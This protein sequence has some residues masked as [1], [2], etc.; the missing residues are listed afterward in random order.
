MS[1]KL[2]IKKDGKI[3]AQSESDS[4]SFTSDI[5][6]GTKI[7]NGDFKASYKNSAGESPEI[8]VPE[9]YV[10]QSTMTL[11]LVEFFGDVSGMSKDDKKELSVKYTDPSNKYNF[12]GF[13]KVGWQGMSS[14]NYSKKNYSMKIYTDDTYS[15][16][17]PVQVSD[18]WY[19]TNKYVLKADYVDST[20][21]RNIVGAKL[22]KQVMA[23]PST[24][25]ILG[26]DDVYKK[27]ASNGMYGSIDGFPCEVRINDEFMGLYTFNLDN[28]TEMTNVQDTDIKAIQMNAKGWGNVTM[29]WD[30]NAKLDGSSGDFKLETPDEGDRLTTAQQAVYNWIAFT[31][32]YGF[33][34]FKQNYG[35]RYNIYNVID[36]GLLMN[37]MN[38]QDN[39]CNNVGYL[40]L[41]G[42]M[43]F[44]LPYDMDGAFDLTF[45]GLTDY[46]RKG[47]VVGNKLLKLAFL[48]YPDVAVKRWNDLRKNVFTKENI[49]KILD[50]FKTKVGEYGYTLDKNVWPDIPSRKYATYEQIEQGIDDGLNFM[51]QQAKDGFKIVARQYANGFPGGYENSNKNILPPDKVSVESDEQGVHIKDGE[52][53]ANRDNESLIL[54]DKSGNQV[55]KSDASKEIT[56][57][58]LTSGTKVNTGDYYLIY[59]EENIDSPKVDVPEFTV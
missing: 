56:I 51:D 5:Q 57:T 47:W 8:D 38:A 59:R 58:G 21:V 35:E 26:Q 16:K 32:F 36:Y 34:S 48:S 13:V 29:G 1:K 3:I 50:D 33:D 27:L 19:A 12:E 25:D 9:T 11:P 15:T 49:V 6:A 44:M 30:V 31:Q 46:S 42:E 40:S 55:S 24:V 43:F 22:W 14:I 20:H 39:V 10:T 17:K 41:N 4:V 7:E 54:F 37:F 28:T 53:Y 18:E 23:D 52:Q 2:I 45:G